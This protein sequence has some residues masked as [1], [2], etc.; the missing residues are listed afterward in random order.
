MHLSYKAVDPLGEARSDFDI[1]CDFGR[2]MDFRDKDN[3]PLMPWKE[4]IEAFE[5]WKR[6]SKG[7]PCDYSGLI[8]DKLTRGSGIQWPCN[9]KNPYSLERLFGD[10]QF[11]TDVDVYKSFGYNLKTGAPINKVR[12]HRSPEIREY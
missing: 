12:V 3:E 1:F 8:Y 7:R 9:E 6:V 11:F 4:P 5:A 10:A 2:K